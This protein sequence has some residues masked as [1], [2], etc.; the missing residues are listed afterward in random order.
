VEA[1]TIPIRAG[2]PLVAQA[3]TLLAKAMVIEHD[4]D[5]LW[6]NFREQ[7]DARRQELEEA[8]IRE[9]LEPLMEHFRPDALARV[10]ATLAEEQE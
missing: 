5:R 2:D 10:A 4:R 8:G 6:K 7:V 9:A 3:V 1:S